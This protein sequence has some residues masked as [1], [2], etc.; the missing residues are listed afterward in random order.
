MLIFSCCFSCSAYITV[1]APTVIN[2]APTAAPVLF[3]TIDSGDGSSNSSGDGE[4][5]GNLVTTIIIVCVV[6]GGGLALLVGGTV[7]YLTQDGQLSLFNKDKY[8]GDVFSGSA[9]KVGYCSNLPEF[10]GIEFG[11]SFDDPVVV[12]ASAVSSTVNEANKSRWGRAPPHRVSPEPY[13]DDDMAMMT[14][15]TH[16]E[17]FDTETIQYSCWTPW[18]E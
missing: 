14:I 16:E 13:E 2:T 7:F 9:R 18:S 10:G 15:Y 12:P 5:G 17:V 4:S 3:P 1:R 6:C 8:Y 11:I